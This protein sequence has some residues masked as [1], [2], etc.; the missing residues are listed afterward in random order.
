[1]HKI[2]PK[3]ERIIC[4]ISVLIQ[5]FAILILLQGGSVIWLGFSDKIVNLLC[6]FFCG[7]SLF[8]RFNESVIKKQ[9]GKT[10]YDSFILCN[11]NLFL[12]NGFKLMIGKN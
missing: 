5:T 4:V 6:Y 9:K 10:I 1:M 2:L 8:Q 3:K 7:L 11:C 12:V